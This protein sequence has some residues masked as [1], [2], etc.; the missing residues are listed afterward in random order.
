[1][2]EGLSFVFHIFTIL[3]AR[4]IS[5]LAFLCVLNTNSEIILFS[6]IC[7]NFDVIWGTHTHKMEICCSVA[8]LDFEY[9][10]HIKSLHLKHALQ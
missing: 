10:L 8:Y 3:N 2:S 9:F 6:L 7:Q 4:L 1:M 5:W